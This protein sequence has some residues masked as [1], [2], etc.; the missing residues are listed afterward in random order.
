MPARIEIKCEE[1]GSSFE[2]QEGDR[3]KEHYIQEAGRCPGSGGSVV[4][5]SDGKWREPRFLGYGEKSLSV[6]VINI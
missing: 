1:C 5:C 6:G 3:I 2:A 4:R